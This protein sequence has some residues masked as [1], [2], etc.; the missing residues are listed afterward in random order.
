MNDDPAHRPNPPRSPALAESGH[1]RH[2]TWHPS[3]RAERPSDEG[4]AERTASRHGHV[5]GLPIKDRCLVMG[6]LNVTPDSFSDGGRYL[7]L[8]QAVDHG[9]GLA[10]A[11]ADIVD[12]GGESTRP[13]AGRV[14][15]DEEIARVLPVVRELVNAGV[16]VSVDTTRSQVAQAALEAG[17]TAINDVSGGLADPSMAAV[18]AEA[19]APYIVMHWR[20]PS[21]EMDRYAVYRDVVADVA[22]ELSRRVET[23][24][25]AGVDPTR[26]IVDP[27][28][29][30]AK[31]TA[32]NWELLSG[33]HELHNLGYPILVGASRKSFLGA[34]LGDD[35]GTPAA[36][37]RD[38]ATAA[39]SALAAAA[40]AFC[41]RVHDVGPTLDAVH[42]AAMWTA[43]PHFDPAPMPT[44]PT[45][46]RWHELSGPTT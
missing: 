37:D 26:I 7:Q 1:S 22:A 28:L 10:A 35:R 15:P 32:H 24:V 19:R 33:L 34:L 8:S 39:V 41:V 5:K 17:A 43:R 21:R 38:A 3:T 25:D 4:P 6:I 44:L 2:A 31:K 36:P 11:G 14:R 16:T 42:V 29:G 13:G 18:I 30:F 45:L 9:L 46:C 23:L 27:G 20:A 12:V 40:G